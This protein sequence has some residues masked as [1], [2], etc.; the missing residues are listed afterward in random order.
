MDG[1]P[2]SECP[3]GGG[4][5][6]D[7]WTYFNASGG[8]W[9]YGRDNPF[10]RRMVDGEIMGWRFNIA[11]ADSDDA[12]RP[13]IGPSAAMFPPLTPATTAPAPPP[14]GGGGGGGGASGSGGSGGSGGGGAAGGAPAVSIPDLSGLL[15]GSTTTVAPEEAT[16]TT[17]TMVE[18]STDTTAAADLSYDEELAASMAASDQ[19]SSP[20]QWVGIVLAVVVAGALVVGAVVRTRSRSQS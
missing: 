7:Y 20:G 3:V 16:T 4:G 14:S 1:F 10:T 13:R 15:E 19:G 2:A 9:V 5:P 18:E 8:G 6:S 12:A 17:S 11:T